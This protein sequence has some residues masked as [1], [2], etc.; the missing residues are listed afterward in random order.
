MLKKR[1]Q[2]FYFLMFVLQSSMNCHCYVKLLLNDK[3][4]SS[5]DVELSLNREM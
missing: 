2:S 1:L 5:L 4:S 3:L